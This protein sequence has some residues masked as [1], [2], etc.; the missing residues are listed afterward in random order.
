[1]VES[2][3]FVRRPTLAEVF[4]A[5]SRNNDLIPPSSHHKP[6]FLVWT[7]ELLEE[8]KGNAIEEGFKGIPM[9]PC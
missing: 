8:Y 4:L 3:R 2:Q 1:M 5:L 6:R 7:C 9:T